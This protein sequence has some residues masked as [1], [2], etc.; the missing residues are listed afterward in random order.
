M[1]E[2]GRSDRWSR[3]L[4]EKRFGGDPGFE[5]EYVK[6][7]HRVRDTVL[8]SASLTE[9]AVVLDVGAGD[10]LIAFGALQRIRP[11]GRVIFA[12][13]SQPLLD[14]SHTLAL[15]KGVADRCTFIRASAE[16]LRSVP[17]ESVDAVTTRSVLIFVADK[18]SAFREFHRVLRPG[19]RIS[20][21]EPINRYAALTEPSTRVC[22]VGVPAIADLAQRLW[23][24][25]R[26]LQPL[27]T[28]PMMNFDE[29]DLVASCE[30]SGFVDIHLALHIL[31]RPRT[32]I[33]WEV[34]LNA[35]G[36][37]HI[38]SLA[39]AIAQLFTA[40]EAARYEKHV[41]PLVEAG[42]GVRREAIAYLVAAKP[43]EH[44]RIEYLEPGRNE[45]PRRQ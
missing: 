1:I 22:G 14:H 43:T 33:K 15:Q 40:D 21:F 5:A 29:R 3:W 32:P 39:E 42:R 24:F 41:R 8:D 28:D 17:D 9:G 11:T 37:P 12:D 7:L 10:G 4:L 38:P 18:G 20:L 23:T 16:D 26:G 45:S 44:P 25:Y 35:S 31:V 6:V 19:G 36:N 13:I 27:E 34:A 2:P 30:G